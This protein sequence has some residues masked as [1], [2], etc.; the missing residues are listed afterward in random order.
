[1]DCITTRVGGNGIS[2][3]ELLRPEVHNAINR[4]LIANLQS[5]LERLQRDGSVRVVV[6]TGAGKSFCAGAD[7][8]ALRA[9]A[10][11]SLEENI[12]DAT[13]LADLLRLLNELSK[14]TIARVHGPADG[15]GL[16]LIAC[17]DIAIAVSKA[18]FS[19][20]EV[21]LGIV[22]AVISPYVIGAIGERQA[23]R[24]LL[25]AERFD[26]QE[27]KRIG[28]VHEVV[29]SKTLDSAVDLVCARII[30]GGPNAIRQTK[31]LIRRSGGDLAKI[32]AEARASI[33]AKEGI[34]AFFEKRKSKW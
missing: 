32:N 24:Y 1:M 28:L 18:V 17:C 8:E 7:L 4:E 33:E 34:A 20:S 14:P 23:R 12:A 3:I 31:D 27:A 29:E 26:A 2:H 13:K 5:E 22:P 30:E 6:L 15:G 21:R 16:G 25:S 19:F 11:L 9:S 10:N